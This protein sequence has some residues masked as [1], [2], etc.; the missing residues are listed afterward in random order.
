MMFRRT[1]LAACAGA[2]ILTTAIV[3]PASQAHASTPWCTAKVYYNAAGGGCDGNLTAGRDRL[4]VECKVIG[5]DY[6]YWNYGSLHNRYADWQQMVYCSSNA[7][8]VA[9]GFDH[10]N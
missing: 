5:S 6:Y 9:A 4:G 3:L 8:S 1:F 10:Q 2:S 7:V